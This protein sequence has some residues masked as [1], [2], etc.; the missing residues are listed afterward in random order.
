MA[1]TDAQKVDYLF[2][3][4][5]SGVA[6]TDTSSAKSPSNETEASPIFIRGDVVWTDAGDIPDPPAAV[7]GKV[8]EYTPTSGVKCVE[9]TTSANDRTWLC[10]SGG[11]RLKDWIPPEFKGGTAPNGYNV[12]VY[13]DTSELGGDPDLDASGTQLFS[14]TSGEEW[15]FDYSAG[16]L[17]F[18]GDN[19]PSAVSGKVVWIVGYRYTGNKGVVSNIADL[20]DVIITS[21]ADGELLRYNGTSWINNTLADAGIALSAHNHDTAYVNVTGDTMTDALVV[22]GS[23]DAVQLKVQGHTTQTNSVFRVEDSDAGEL[24]KIANSGF[25]NAKNAEFSG[26]VEVNRD[27]TNFTPN[28]EA[29][30][31]HVDESTLTDNVT[32]ATGTASSDFH[33]VYISQITVDAT[34]YDVTTTNA[35]SLYIANAPVSAGGEYPLVIRNPYALWVDAGVTRL[36][37]D[38]DL[39]GTQIK[40][41]STNGYIEIQ[42]DDQ[43][44]VSMGSAINLGRATADN[45]AWVVA[46]DATDNS[47][48]PLRLL[49]RHD[50][51]DTSESSTQFW[52]RETATGSDEVWKGTVHPASI[53]LINDASANGTRI[54][55]HASAAW[56]LTLP[57]GDGNDNE[58][59]M[60]DGGGATSWVGFGTATG[61]ISEGDHN[62]DTAY[63]AISHNH[64]G[65]YYTETESDEKFLRAFDAWTHR[66]SGTQPKAATTAALPAS[67]YTKDAVPDPDEYRLTASANGPLP[68]QDAITLALNERLLVKDQ[69]ADVEN[70]VYEVEQVGVT[71]V[72]PWKLK[73][74]GTLDTAVE[75]ANTYVMVEGGATN[76]GVW[77]CV[78]TSVNSI[79]PAGTG[80]PI[81]K[82]GVTSSHLINY[83]TASDVVLGR[84]TANAG[85]IEEITYATL[86]T[87]LV[88]G[89][90]T[91][92]MDGTA[93]TVPQPL[94]TSDD[95]EK[96]LR[97][98]A[99]W[100]VPSGTTYTINTVSDATDSS[101]EIIRITGSDGTADDIILKVGDGLS[102]SE[103][104][105]TI[106][107]ANTETNTDTTYTL[108]V[109]DSTTVIRLSDSVVDNDVTVTAG[110]GIDVVRDSGSQLTFSTDI[111]ASGGLEI[112]STELKVDPAIYLPRSPSTLEL[113]ET[114]VGFERGAASADTNGADL[115][116][117]KCND[118]GSHT[119]DST[120]TATAITS[121]TQTSFDVDDASSF[122]ATDDIVV[123][124][125][126]TKEEMTI[127]SISVNTLTV[128]RGVNTTTAASSFSIGSTVTKLSVKNAGNI[129]LRTGSSSGTGSDGGEDG[130][131]VWADGGEVVV[132]NS[133]SVDKL[134]VKSTGQIRSASGAYFDGNSFRM[135][136]STGG[137]VNLIA[138]ETGSGTGNF[139][140]R[141]SND[142]KKLQFDYPAVGGFILFRTYDK[143]TKA[144]V[145]K[146]V[147]D[148]SGNFAFNKSSANSRF[149]IKGGVSHTVT[150]Y[151]AATASLG[152]EDRIV[153]ADCKNN[154]IT[155]TLPVWADGRVVDI[156]YGD[157]TADGTGDNSVK[158]RVLVDDYLN[159]Y[160]HAA[161]VAA[162]AE[163][164]EITCGAA[165]VLEGALAMTGDYINLRNGSNAKRHIWFNVDTNT[166][167]PAPSGSTALEVSLGSTDSST[168]C[169]TSI[170]NA[171]DA[172]SDFSATV[173]SNVVTITNA[174]A[175]SAAPNIAFGYPYPD[176]PTGWSTATPTAGS[177]AVAADI[178]EVTINS[179]SA[180]SSGRMLGNGVRCVAARKYS[181]RPHWVVSDITESTVGVVTT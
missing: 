167:D 75:F 120:T 31:I 163:V 1:I 141:N 133:G 119:A 12:K 164:H 76:K 143:G 93:G 51:V 18:I 153:W 74:I 124:E 36:D 107:F 34:N 44:G 113:A 81:Y 48:R 111:A 176:P 161:A 112:S 147:V 173:S 15:F 60:T 125:G 151:T 53:I 79:E 140:F 88:M 181:G 89:G 66:P 65:R 160:K 122:S 159:G 72:S 135:G 64:D 170:K 5:G 37:G 118:A 169:A 33:T 19:V 90:A 26:K 22:D 11:T 17:H 94:S 3:K 67:T 115:V 179:P 28:D 83:A 16:I 91:S 69:A 110:D 98:D 78:V 137:T 20:G 43:V 165:D 68:A 10:D 117:A 114:A 39:R 80:G 32:G 144:T 174:V 54:K 6:K 136:P 134:R 127:D 27:N 70:G 56:T 166:S 85:K 162:V 145:D 101:R 129:I 77:S 38:L 35:A 71:D 138:N 21:A 126:S 40:N 121:S 146:M 131:G 99:T 24:F 104:G 45:H 13:A 49:S 50:T 14:T 103:G 47:H 105:D 109:P 102:I 180:S 139:N 177:N 57:S 155:L 97:G 96:F 108:D 73:R 55:T 9:D 2:K 30:A 86:N 95:D 142:N 158:V 150:K 132:Q 42:S 52:S 61:K 106:T 23:A 123:V 41:T 92:S 62:H 171:V 130:G 25:I 149:N 168:Q 128:T 58:F 84:T 29:K 175:G 100:V 116:I 82:K 59:L 8:A 154:N 148:S 172:D 152:D 156:Y 178:P 46:G 4:I 63:A 157:E 87:D 7:D